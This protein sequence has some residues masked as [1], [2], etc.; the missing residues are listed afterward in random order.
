M[1]APPPMMNSKRSL[2]FAILIPI[3]G[4][5]A[6]LGGGAWFVFGDPMRNRQEFDSVAWQS[7]QRRVDG[8]RVRMVDDLLRRHDFRGLSR[9][10]VT[11]ILGEPD[12][13]NHFRNWDMVY[14]LGPERGFMGVDSEWLVFRLDEL[15]RAAE[16]RVLSD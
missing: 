16:Y 3:L 1:A 13:T 7:T 15:N 12:K 6:L 2:R 9:V 5:I 14:F 8:V 4:I 10:D 11:A